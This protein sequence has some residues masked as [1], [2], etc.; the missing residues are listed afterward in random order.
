MKPVSAHNVFDDNPDIYDALVDWPRRLGR[1]EPFY[2][3][4]FERFAVRRVLD[5][6]CGTGHHAAMFASWGLEVEGADNSAAMIE[7]CRRR[8]GE[9]E[10]LRWRVRSFEQPSNP[11]EAFDAVLCTGNSLSL[12]SDEA[13]AEQAVRALLASTRGGGICLI[14]VLNLWRLAEGPTLWQKCRR[15]QSGGKDF[16]LLKGLHRAGSRGLIDFLRLDLEG[17]GVSAR[18]N[19]STL[20]GLAADDLS[21]WVRGHGGDEIELFGNYARDPYDPTRSDDLILLCRR[22]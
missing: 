2:R 22:K 11:P 20:L 21:T 8:W 13:A 1:E 16:V 5:A 18:Y 19:T 3:W 7:H 10:A 15:M 6:A 12:A 4:V 17:N 14:H 9:G